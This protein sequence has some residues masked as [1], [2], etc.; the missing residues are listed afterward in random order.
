MIFQVLYRLYAI[1]VV[2]AGFKLSANM[3]LTS[4][5]HPKV[6]EQ[7]DIVKVQEMPRIVINFLF[8]IL[9]S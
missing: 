4:M 3:S 7:S 5:H 2:Q 9:K 8:R 1:M 6:S